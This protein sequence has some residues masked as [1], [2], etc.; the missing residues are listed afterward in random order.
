MDG[1]ISTESETVSSQIESM[2]VV[3]GGTSR[4]ERTPGYVCDLLA[5]QR[6]ATGGL[7]VLA[8]QGADRQIQGVKLMADHNGLG[9]KVGECL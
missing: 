9:G 7:P 3:D 6:Y 8:G 1:L 4:F 5:F 2:S